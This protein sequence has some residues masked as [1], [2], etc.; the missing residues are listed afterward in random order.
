MQESVDLIELLSKLINQDMKKLNVK[1]TERI[2]TKYNNE[3]KCCFFCKHGHM[4]ENCRCL[5]N[6]FQASS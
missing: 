4:I 5:K 1:K 2:I 3:I 6:S